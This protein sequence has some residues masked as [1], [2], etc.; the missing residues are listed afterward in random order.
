MP[1]SLAAV[2]ATVAAML[3]PCAAAAHPM[4]NFSIN[5]YAA[6]AVTPARVELRYLIDMAEI[7]TFQEMHEHG[8]AA[9]P[10]DPRLASYLN[11]K[12]SA[13]RDNLTLEADGKRLVL[14]E[15]GHDAI[16]PPGAGGLPTMKLGMRLVAALAPLAF[17]SGAT[18]LSRSQF[19]RPC[20]M[21]GSDRRWRR[22][23]RPGLF[24]RAATRPQR[25]A[26]QLSG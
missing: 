19:P 6:I 4:G 16:F 21:E 1:A 7:P 8:F 3:L 11:A 18:G 26:Q 24:I 25:A 17:E 20:G 10:A 15:L 12:C 2:I 13:L 9:D 23:R 5:H 14:R 22:R